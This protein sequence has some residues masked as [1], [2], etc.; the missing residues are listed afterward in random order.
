MFINSHIASGYIAS[1]FETN[2]K[3][4]IVLW[5][6][7]AF[8]PDIDGLWSKTV[9]D[10]HSVLHTPI[11]WIVICGTG[12]LIG[13]F[14]NDK[15]IKRISYILFLGTQIHLMTDYIT[16]RTVGIKWLYPFNDVDY[17]L[18]GIIPEKGEIPVW[19]MLVPP[20]ISF[21][22]ENRVLAMFEVMINIIALVLYFFSGKKAI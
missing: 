16:A 7:A 4:W 10:H 17:F 22:F 9:V 12:W 21:Y 20:Y 8:V 6:F 14:K 1:W 5:V 15:I 13:W 11:F 3:E 2:K 18:Y 19:E